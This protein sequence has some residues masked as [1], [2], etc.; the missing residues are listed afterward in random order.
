M[1]KELTN[2]RYTR[3]CRREVLNQFPKGQIIGPKKYIVMC[4]PTIT[5]INLPQKEETF[6]TPLI[7]NLDISLGP[8]GN[9]TSND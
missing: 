7:E 8:R 1:Y 5:Q 9:S 6:Y 2:D 4:V 3:K